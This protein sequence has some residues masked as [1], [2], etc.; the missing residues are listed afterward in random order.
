MTDRETAEII[1]QR[2]N[3]PAGS[4]PSGSVRLVE[5]VLQTSG[6]EQYGVKFVGAAPF[7]TDDVVNGLIAS[8]R[9]DA[10]APSGS[11]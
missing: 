6:P 11:A 3:R 1:A 5:V 7:M 4:V 9:I 2:G 10:T 8:L